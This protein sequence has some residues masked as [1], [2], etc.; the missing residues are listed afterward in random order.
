[1]GYC[2]AVRAGR[3]NAP[4]GRKGG[5]GDRLET[6]DAAQRGLRT[7][8]GGGA[9]QGAVIRMAEAPAGW[10]DVGLGPLGHRGAMVVY[11]GIQA[12]QAGARRQEGGQQEERLGPEEVRSPTGEEA[13]HVLEY[14]QARSTAVLRLTG[15]SAGRMNQKAAP[16]P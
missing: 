15:P 11:Q 5:T 12:R 9:A 14:S 3:L 1:L 2:A 10:L 7:G 6:G 4:G 13:A 8:T 16:R